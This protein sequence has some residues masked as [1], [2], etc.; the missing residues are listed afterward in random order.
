M[1]MPILHPLRMEAIIYKGLVIS[2]FL[3]IYVVEASR[4]SGINT[5]AEFVIENGLDVEKISPC[6]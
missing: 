5:T 2:Q 4:N 3:P 6:A 1:H